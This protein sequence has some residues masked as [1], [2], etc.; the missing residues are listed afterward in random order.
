LWPEIYRLNTDV[1]EDPH[2]IYPGER[3]RIPGAA[4]AGEPTVVSGESEPSRYGPT[5]FS[6]GIARGTVSTGRLSLVGRT[7]KPLVRPGEYY[8]A[9]YVERDGGPDGAGSIVGSAD[10]PGIAQIEARDRLL[11]QD[12]ILIVPPRGSVAMVGT[13][14]L[15][16]ALGPTIPGAGQVVVPTGV[17]EVE[18]ETKGNELTHAR[19]VDA[20][21]TMQR[22]QKLIRLDS[23]SFPTDVQPKSIE[24]GMDAKVLWL[25]GGNVLPSIHEYLVLD[26][27]VR[28]GVRPG[29]QFTLF[30]A[31]TR[32][33]DGHK[34]PA[35]PVAI[36]QV[37]RVT[38]FG[39]TAMILD[40]AQPAIREGLSARMT[41]KVQ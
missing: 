39:T 17:V 9:P 2:W 5:A 24:L 15:V 35:E 37:I 36:A 32:T 1:V 25:R 34:V 28:D 33:D 29:D 21:E 30:R 41:A 40:Q 8:A 6:K 14:Y 4:P 20:F 11:L 27:T 26:R 3:L 38:P 31:A 12:R 23:V 13:R 10:L 16:Y 7:P 18:Q 19:V 22:G